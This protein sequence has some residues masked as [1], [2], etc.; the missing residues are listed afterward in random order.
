[1]TVVRKEIS[2]RT[3]SGGK[4]ILVSEVRVDWKYRMFS[5]LES[6]IPS[7]LPC[8]SFSDLTKVSDNAVHV[9]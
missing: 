1:M 3:N 5:G 8:I 2:G 7:T 6:S 4:R 9:C